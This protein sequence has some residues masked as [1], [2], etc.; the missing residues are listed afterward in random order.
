MVAE[1]L[2]SQMRQCKVRMGKDLWDITAS[3][4]V[5][6]CT[7][8]DRVMDIMLSAEGALANAVSGGGDQVCVG[9]TIQE[10]RAAAR[11]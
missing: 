7:M 9:Q 5:A 8:N 11:I 6:H 2:C 4:G 1:R 3:V 10:P